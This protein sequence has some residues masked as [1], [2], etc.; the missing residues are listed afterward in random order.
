MK[1]LFGGKYII[2]LTGLL[3]SYTGRI[4]FTAKTLIKLPQRNKS[5]Q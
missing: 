3:L 2:L 5:D 4:W 1:N